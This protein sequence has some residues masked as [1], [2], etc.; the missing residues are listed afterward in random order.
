MF[1]KKILLFLIVHLTPFVLFAQISAFDMVAQMGRGINLG[2]V[3]SAPEFEGK[4]AAAA[5][6]EYFNDIASAGFTNVRIPMDFFGYR[7]TGNTSD[8][9]SAAGTVLEY[10]GIPSDYIVLSTYLDRIEEVIRWALLED[11]IVILDF[12]GSNL[13]SEFI[14]TFNSAKGDLYTYPTSAKRA[15]DNEKFRAIWDQIAKRF[16]GHSLNLLFEVI[17]EPYFNMSKEEMDTLNMAVLD[18]IRDSGGNNDTRNVI[19][20]GGGETSHEAPLQIDPNII[21]GDPYLIATF[22]YYQPYNF[23]SSSKISDNREESWGIDD[24]D[25]L[26]RRFNEVSTWAENNSIP[27]FLGEFGA[28]NTGG[29]NYRTGDLN[30]VQANISTGYAVGGPDNASRVEYHR[31]VAEQAISRGFSF[32]AWDAGPK[33]NKTIHKRTDNPSSGNYD[34]N[35]FSVNNYDPKDTNISTVPDNSVWVEDVKNALLAI[36]TTY[37]NGDWEAGTTWV[38]GIVPTSADNVIIN[39]HTV[40]IKDA[41]AIN[42]LTI[43]EGGKLTINSGKSID[44]ANNLINDGSVGNILFNA[45]AN[46]P[47]VLKIGGIYTGENIKFNH[48]MSASFNDEWVLIAAPF[49]QATIN[50]YITGAQT[51]VINEAGDK[52]ALATYNDANTTLLKYIYVTKPQ[53][54]TIDQFVDG[55]GY[56]TKLKNEDD[57][58]R[59]TLQFKGK[60]QDATTVNFPISG[61]G[62]GFKLVG[63]PYSTWLFANS[64]ADANN[65]LSTNSTIL[66][67]DTMWLWDSENKKFITKNQE[68]TAFKIAPTQGFFVKAKNDG[69]DFS[70]AKD[71]QTVTA[72]TYY[73][74]SNTRFEINLF[75][76][77]HNNERNTTIRYINNRTTSFDNGSDS[78]LFGGVS[79]DLSIYTELIKNN[80]GKKL[81]IQSLPNSNFENMVIPVGIHTVVESEITFTVDALNVPANYKVYLED[82]TNN[83]VTRLDEANAAYKVS[84]ESGITNG[85][86]YLHTK[87]SSVL[88]KDSNNLTTVSMYTTSNSNLRIH[89]LKEGNVSISI[90]NTLGK[91]IF[92]TSF[93]AANSINIALPNLAKGVYLVQLQNA[94]GKLNKKIILE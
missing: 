67:E 80:I 33:S 78:S 23:T 65:L 32:A 90:F 6:P 16:K 71:M 92:H 46:G 24:Y 62:N 21:S 7:T 9:N 4:W 36:T 50:D 77:S 91:Q 47:G 88:S 34:I 58:S 86:F 52:Y 20:T 89:G 15:A 1:K 84:I 76:A 25:L 59:P 83:T 82:R 22:H 72:D 57:A 63:N 17:N 61:A 37:Q 30:A 26:I 19:I 8:Y 55:Q 39:G 69:G 68:D 49:K 70:F 27:I 29:Y 10:D 31:Y 79:D 56:A 28:D 87:T 5:T 18:I 93:E 11:L 85:R 73:K 44:I 64:P 3:F 66:Y 41:A 38:G 75:I 40:I 42:K 2:N 13:K 53:P 94:Q 81:A 60:P 54:N 48:R 43:N 12:H 35:N 45:G 51:I 14:Y 74:T